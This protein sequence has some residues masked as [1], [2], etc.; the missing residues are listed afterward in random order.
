MEPCVTDSINIYYPVVKFLTPE[1]EWITKPS[2]LSVI[3]GI[4]KKGKEVNIKYEINHP[5][6]FFIKDKYTYLIPTSMIII[7]LLFFAL[8]ISYLLSS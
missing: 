7:S 1:N 8:G 2:K 3:P 6:N 4:Y 5:N